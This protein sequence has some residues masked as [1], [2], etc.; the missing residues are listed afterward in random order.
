MRINPYKHFTGAWIPNWLLGRTEISSGAK[1]AYARLAQFAGEDGRAYPKVSTLA[2]ALGVERKQ[3][4][5]YLSELLN[6]NLIE[7]EH[8]F[9]TSQASDYFFLNHMWMDTPCTNMSI[10]PVQI[11]PKNKRISIREE[12]ILSDDNFETFWSSYPRHDGKVQA[13]KVWLKRKYSTYTIDLIMKAVE[14][15][16]QGEGCLAREKKYIP[17]AATWLNQ[18]RYLDEIQEDLGLGYVR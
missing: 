3:A 18:E 13:K 5:R 6:F 12:S 4:Q 17:H 10:P 2:E 15:Q 11:C 1:I 14:S 9:E 8:H 7:V 16:K